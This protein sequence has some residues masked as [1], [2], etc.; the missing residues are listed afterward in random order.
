LGDSARVLS[1]TQFQDRVTEDAKLKDYDNGNLIDHPDIRF[2]DT[3]QE[4]IE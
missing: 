2:L 4:N 3:T 1:G